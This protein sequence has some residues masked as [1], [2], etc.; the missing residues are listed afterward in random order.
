MHLDGREGR[1]CRGWWEKIIQCLGKPCST[2]FEDKE[3]SHG[4]LRVK[5][6]GWPPRQ[7]HIPRAHHDHPWRLWGFEWA[8]LPVAH[9]FEHLTLS[10]WH[11]V[12]EDRDL[13]V[14]W[15]LA[16]ERASLGW[17]LSEFL[18]SPH[19]SPCV[20]YMQPGCGFLA[21]FSGHHASHL[22]P[23]PPRLLGAVPLEP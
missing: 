13:F 3:V 11:C 19:C 12:G 9:V 4:E 21:A 14:M 2:H 1:K 7:R 5:V 18:A 22:L 17:G 8:M 6:D 15:S 10:L 20:L 16:G 23:W